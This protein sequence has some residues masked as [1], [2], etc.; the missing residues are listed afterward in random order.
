MNQRVIAAASAAILLTAGVAVAQVTPPLVGTVRERA[1][2]IDGAC[3]SGASVQ[4]TI[5]TGTAG[6]DVRLSDAPCVAGRFSANAQA[7]QLV[8]GFQVQAVQVVGGTASGPM[9]VP[10]QALEGPYGD[11]RQAFEANAY[12]G[13]AIDTFGAQE[14]NEYLN[15]EA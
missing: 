15:P 9:I 7:I 5:R 13:L 11:E 10:V 6:N 14:L 8:E 4:L 12:I 3:I 1:A 2:T